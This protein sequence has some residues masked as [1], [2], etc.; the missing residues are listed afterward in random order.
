[1]IELSGW[2]LLDTISHYK[3]NLFL[4]FKVYT[5]E[6]IP[7]KTSKNFI[8]NWTLVEVAFVYQ[9]KKVEQWKRG[10]WQG[11]HLANTNPPHP[12]TARCPAAKDYFKENSHHWSWAVQWLQKKVTAP[13]ALLAVTQEAVKPPWRVLTWDAACQGQF[14]HLETGLRVIFRLPTFFR[15]VDSLSLHMKFMF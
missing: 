2:G 15:T 9:N 13:R 11:K 12:S 5:W 10:Y 8:D 6:R 4:L 1:M 3:F 14:L 7:T